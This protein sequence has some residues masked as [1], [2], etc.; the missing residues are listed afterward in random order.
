MRCH[1][2]HSD[3]VKQFSWRVKRRLSLGFSCIVKSFAHPSGFAPQTCNNPWKTLD[4]PRDLLISSELIGSLKEAGIR[5]DPWARELIDD[6]LVTVPRIF[7]VRVTIGEVGL[8]KAASTVELFARIR[9]LGLNLCPPET[10]P[11]LRLKYTEQSLFDDLIV[12]MLPLADRLRRPHAFML[13]RDRA[14]LLLDTVYLRAEESWREDQA[15]VFCCPTTY[16]QS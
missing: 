4:R 10:G 8:T 11:L 3:F 14:G 6:W 9:R 2:A 13:T 15:F 1:L 7:L 12:G 5:V 16:N